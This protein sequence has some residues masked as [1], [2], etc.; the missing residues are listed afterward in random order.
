MAFPTLK[1][2]LF[3]GLEV[4]H[5]VV[6]GALGLA[7][8]ALIRL[9]HAEV[10]RKQKLSRFKP[11]S[12]FFSVDSAY[13]LRPPSLKEPLCP[14]KIEECPAEIENAKEEAEEVEE[15]KEAETFPRPSEVENPQE[16]IAR[17]GS[18][19]VEVA[20]EAS[21]EDTSA[22]PFEELDP[23][24]LIPRPR[25]AGL[26]HPAAAEDGFL[27]LLLPYPTSRLLFQTRSREQGFS[28]LVRHA[29]SALRCSRRFV[30]FRVALLNL[31]MALKRWIINDNQGVKSPAT[32]GD[33]ITI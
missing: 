3:A 5:V 13:D 6:I 27:P 22:P 1:R 2:P 4:I 20:G 23:R 7:T 30:M 11:S 33:I 32:M 25:V 17:P 12:S 31:G 16:D 29:V 8:V 28:D 19:Q 10:Q 26:S 9:L 18:L 15:V 24:L 14:T 21:A